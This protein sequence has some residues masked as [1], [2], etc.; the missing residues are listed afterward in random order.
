MKGRCWTEEE[1]RLLAESVLRSV[2]EGGSQLDAFQEVAEKI[3][4]T[5]GAC[6]FRW[7]AVI[8]KQEAEA[9]RKAKKQRMENQLKRKRSP[10]FTINDVIRHLKEFERE[11]LS[12]RKRLSDLEKKLA[13][14]EEK[15]KVAEEEHSRLTEEWK[16]FES[17]Q[18]EIKDRYTSLLRLFQMAR[19]LEKPEGPVEETEYEESGTKVASK[20]EAES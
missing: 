1:D 9:F 19:H 11:Y 2:K 5:P 13:K 16:A 7:N 17:F 18:N 12:T 14:K 15:L 3:G 20:T 4:R 10:S 8:R 6:G